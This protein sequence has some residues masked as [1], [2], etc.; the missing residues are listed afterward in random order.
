MSKNLSYFKIAA[1]DEWATIEKVIWKY[2]LEGVA[3][4]LFRRTLSLPHLYNNP[5][6]NQ[7]FL[8]LNDNG[9][10]QMHPKHSKYPLYKKVCDEAGNTKLKA[11]GTPE[12]EDY[13]LH[14]RIWGKI[15]RKLMAE[16]ICLRMLGPQ[17]RD[18]SGYFIRSWNGINTFTRLFGNQKMKTTQQETTR[19]F[20]DLMKDYLTRNMPGIKATAETGLDNVMQQCREMY[21]KYEKYTHKEKGEQRQLYY[22]DFDRSAY[23]RCLMKQMDSIARNPDCTEKTRYYLIN[24]E[25][26]HVLVIYAYMVEYVMKW[27]KESTPQQKKYNLFNELHTLDYHKHYTDHITNVK[28]EMNKEKETDENICMDLPRPAN[29]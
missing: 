18:M 3:M 17:D 5:T 29:G 25:Y 6:F 28:D 20:I 19:C 11:D 1:Q 13:K 27:S 22:I 4:S 23:A 16:Y 14:T 8:E 21:N 26:L 7:T 24:E 2:M 9:E 15:F 10:P 12:R